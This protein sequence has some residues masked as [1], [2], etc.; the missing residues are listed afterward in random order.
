M[1]LRTFNFSNKKYNPE[2]WVLKLKEYFEFMKTQTWTKYESIKSGDMAGELISIPIRTPLTRDNLCIFAEISGD[3]LRNYASD[4][5]G[6]ENHF[7][8]TR[9]ALK[10]IDNNQLEGALVGAYNSNLVARLQGLKEEHDHTTNGKDLNNTIPIIN[11]QV[12][13]SKTDFA[14]SESDVDA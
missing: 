4:K 5:Q 1:D 2:E 11:V 13:S 3:T 9:Q 14:S 8:V 12:N 6:Y 7:E 10:Y